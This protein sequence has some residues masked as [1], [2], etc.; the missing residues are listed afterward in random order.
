M[1]ENDNLINVKG[2]GQE[3]IRLLNKLSIFSVW[4]LIT[5]FPKSF[6]NFK[7]YNKIID[8]SNENQLISLK[9]INKEYKGKR[10]S[11][12][13]IYCIDSNNNIVELLCFNRNFYEEYA[14]ADNIIYVFGKF[15]RKIYSS[16][17][18][19][20]SF[21]II[22]EKVAKEFD[23][24]PNYRL[25][26]G[27]TTFILARLI[28]NAL[29]Q[30]KNKIVEILPKNIIEK[31]KFPHF[32]DILY[33]LHFPKTLDIFEKARK[34]Y[35]YYEFFIYL[36]KISLFKKKYKERIENRKSIEFTYQKSFISNLPFKLTIDQVN[37]I[38]KLNSEYKEKYLINTLIHG[39]VGSGKTVVSF[40]FILN[41]VEA[42]YQAAFMAPTEILA[43]QH[44]NNFLNL[45]PDIKISFLSSSLKKSE[46][47]KELENI[48]KGETKIVFGT[49][50]IITD[51]VKFQNLKLAIIDE[52]QQFGVNQRINLRQKGKDVDLL[53]LSAT[54]IPRT[55]YLS[56]YGDLNII[57]I[58]QMPENRKPVKTYFFYDDEISKITDLINKELTAG[59]SGFFV[60][61]VINED[62]EL[63][64]KSAKE[65]YENI[66][67][68][69]CKYKT[70][71]IHGQMK[72]E[73]I[74]KIMSD[75][76]NRKFQLLVSTTIVAVGID[77]PH[78]TFIV[79]E[80]SQ[81]FGLSTLHQLRGRVGRNDKP[82][83]CILT[84]PKN[85]TDVARKRIFKLCETND[86]FE[87]AEFDLKLR[88][89]GEIFGIKQS[90]EINFKLANF[91]EDHKIFR[92]A[93]NDVKNLLEDDPL[94]KKEENSSLKNYLNNIEKVSELFLLSG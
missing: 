50:S 20:S 74:D 66:K 83:I 38:E 85:I 79:I 28:K 43:K 75:F 6:F 23:Y 69:F 56:L 64:L 45:C 51:N 47:E 54:P 68:R 41:Y 7:T 26:K 72:D 57:S 82:S 18:V 17:F 71:L 2:I 77:I 52:Q 24:Y 60:Y 78:A 81:R 46:R 61:P 70:E 67:K 5:Y 34:I 25:T 39:D 63:E 21:K 4:D 11:I 9:V 3:T 91:S 87:I 12:L 86:G 90:G 80:E 88:G 84:A 37:A 35:A 42:G 30:Y 93:Y 31:Y 89:P 27:I 76:K 73:D 29:L 40:A 32:Y 14:I 22:S 94:L 19:S 44:Y 48:E 58:K 10:G 62:N 53:V 33:S 65:M 49:H 92:F 59:N 16:H 1:F 13:T 8:N 55:I 15:K 36:L